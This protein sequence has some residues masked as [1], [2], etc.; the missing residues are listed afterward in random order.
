MNLPK[1]EQTF[2]GPR[3]IPSDALFLRDL[4]Q[5]LDAVVSA[6]GAP[7]ESS[8]NP[9]IGEEEVAELLA[10][11]GLRPNSELVEW[12]G[13]HNGITARGE[14]PWH[15]AALP[16][17][18]PAS[19]QTLVIRY[20]SSVFEFVVPSDG[21]VEMDPRCFSYGLGHGWLSLEADNYTRYA[22]SCHGEYDAVP[23]IR[24]AGPEFMDR[25]WDDRLQAVS[26]CTPVTWWLEGIRSGAHVWNV[27]EQRWNQPVHSLLPESQRQAGF[28]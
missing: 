21:E 18:M 8:L 15:P 7:V 26:L 14:G 2:L 23:L 20:R 24:R 4:L 28:Y 6:A 25:A 1:I 5:E 17:I 12:F 9:G 27:D 13:W 3:A 19:L 11:V 16:G 10:S 22:V